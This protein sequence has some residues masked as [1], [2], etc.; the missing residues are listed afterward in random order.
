MDV[1]NLFSI[2]PRILT[3]TAIGAVLFALLSCFIMLPTPIPGT[4][5]FPS[6]ALLGLFAALFGPLSGAVISLC[7]MVLVSAVRGVLFESFTLPYSIAAVVCGFIYGLAK[8]YVHADLGEFGYSSVIAY[9]M[10]QIAGNLVSW[11]FVAPLLNLLL[12]PGSPKTE[13]FLQ[14]AIASLVN[15]ISAEFIGTPL[16]FIYSVIRKWQLRRHRRR[17]SAL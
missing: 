15:I 17:Q 9:N 11:G 7:G 8:Q 6:Y 14:G 2:N 4:F 5:F 13:I 10:I 3:A 12:N 1:K 16:L